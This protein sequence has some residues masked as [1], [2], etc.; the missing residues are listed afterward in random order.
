MAATDEAVPC[1]R[2]FSATG[3]VVRLSVFQQ[4][5]VDKRVSSELKL[6]DADHE[7]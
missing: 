7:V 4:R 3:H 2:P 5:A 1:I 6:E